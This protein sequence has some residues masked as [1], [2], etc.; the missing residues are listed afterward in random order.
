MSLFKVSFSQ[1]KVVN[2]EEQC[3]KYSLLD[4]FENVKEVFTWT[5]KLIVSA[6]C[7]KYVRE[8]STFEP[9][10]VRLFVKILVIVRV[11]V[12]AV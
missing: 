4:R 1:S 12:R 9:E 5:A 10:L 2:Q 11:E 8:F 7:V 6:L 3:S